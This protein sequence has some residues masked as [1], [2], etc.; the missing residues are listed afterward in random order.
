MTDNSSKQHQILCLQSSKGGASE[1]GIKLSEDA[2]TLKAPEVQPPKEC[3][4]N[5][6]LVTCSC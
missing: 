3:V 4:S 1:G 5:F 2:Y 6:S